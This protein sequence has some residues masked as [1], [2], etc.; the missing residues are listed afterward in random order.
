MSVSL[1]ISTT[2]PKISYV[3]AKPKSRCW[4][5]CKK[6]K[7]P[8]KTHARELTQEEIDYSVMLRVERSAKK[9]FEEKKEI[10]S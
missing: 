3:I 6:D 10:R 5:C 8:R 9:A 7:K 4:S 2:P 1:G